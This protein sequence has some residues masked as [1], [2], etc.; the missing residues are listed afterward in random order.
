VPKSAIATKKK[1][2]FIWSHHSSRRSQ[3]ER[4]CQ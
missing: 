4:G 1:E 3:T 2:V